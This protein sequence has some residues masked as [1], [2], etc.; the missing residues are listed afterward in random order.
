MSPDDG[1]QSRRS[2]RLEAEPLNARQHDG[3]FRHRKWDASCISR[4]GSRR[5]VSNAGYWH[6]ELLLLFELI[7]TDPFRLYSMGLT[8]S[9]RGA[10]SHFRARNLASGRSPW[11][12]ARPFHDHGVS[13]MAQ[14]RDNGV[15]VIAIARLDDEMQFRALGRNVSKNPLVIDFDDLRRQ[16]RSRPSTTDPASRG[17]QIAS[18]DN[19][20]S[21]ANSRVNTL[22]SSRVS[23]LPPQRISPT[24]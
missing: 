23:I 7:H 16:S 18:R 8:L 21:R 19:R 17:T 24:L 13:G 22:A 4:N 2:R 12:A 10:H 14:F 5:D 11:P 15:D 3:L 20:P 9:R 1:P 6:A